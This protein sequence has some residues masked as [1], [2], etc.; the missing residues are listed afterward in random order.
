M[1]EEPSHLTVST[2]A[3]PISQ[4]VP[5]IVD[6]VAINDTMSQSNGESQRTSCALYALH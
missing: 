3:T 4:Y 1:S 6:D 2:N 5:V